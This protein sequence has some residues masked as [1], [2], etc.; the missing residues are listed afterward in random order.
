[1]YS[2]SL[3]PRHWR[4]TRSL[5]KAVEDERRRV[6]EPDQQRDVAG[7]VAFRLGVIQRHH[8]EHVPV[9]EQD[10]GRHLA[11]RVAQ[12]RPASD[13]RVGVG[14]QKRLGVPG[15]PTGNALARGERRVRVRRQALVRLNLDANDY[16]AKPFRLAALLARLRP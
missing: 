3:T 9:G 2:A 12:H 7:A 6:S 15:D 10:G 1:M 13:V 14:D 5:P 11:S 16:I 8:A 4:Q